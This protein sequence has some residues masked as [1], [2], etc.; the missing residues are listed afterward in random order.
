MVALCFYTLIFLFLKEEKI[1]KKYIKNAAIKKS[2]RKFILK[3]LPI[4][5]PLL[6]FY[7]SELSLSAGGLVCWIKIRCWA[8]PYVGLSM[9]GFI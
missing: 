5:Y 9:D 2:E 3:T 4:K 7:P 8:Y 1:P 6:S